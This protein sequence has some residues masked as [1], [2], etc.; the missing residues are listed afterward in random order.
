MRA[1]SSRLPL[2]GRP[3]RSTR[4]EVAP[5]LAISHLQWTE[6]LRLLQSHQHC[7]HAAKGRVKHGRDGA[8]VSREQ[9]RRSQDP[10]SHPRG[11]LIKTY[12]GCPQPFPS[13][14]RSPDARAMTGGKK[15]GDAPRWKGRYTWMATLGMVVLWV[16][17]VRVMTNQSKTG[18]WEAWHRR[19]IKPSFSTVC[20][21]YSVRQLCT[22]S[23]I[24]ENT[25]HAE[26]GPAS[27]GDR[28]TWQRWRGVHE[29]KVWWYRYTKVTWTVTATRWRKTPSSQPLAWWSSSTR[30]SDTGRSSQ[31]VGTGG[32]AQQWCGRR[33]VRKRHSSWRH[34]HEQDLLWRAKG[35]PRT[36]SDNERDGLV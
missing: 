4:P 26:F 10:P 25:N 14:A 30:P 7:H 16:G 34:A 35:N 19:A 11:G 22:I 20:R 8:W 13:S 9:L 1:G 31:N 24:W 15:T 32:A 12:N 2:S 17:Y 29:F 23:N 28:C 21:V 5:L 18:K 33:H 27:H 36:R 6:W 3:N